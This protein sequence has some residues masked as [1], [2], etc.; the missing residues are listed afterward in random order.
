MNTNNS[1]WRASWV[2]DWAI[3]GWHGVSDTISYNCVS[4]SARYNFVIVLLI[5]FKKSF[6]KINIVSV[7]VSRYRDNEE[8]DR[9]NQMRDELIDFNEDQK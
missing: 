9:D 8:C 6:L 7:A 3:T 5:F 4:D 2:I 1:P